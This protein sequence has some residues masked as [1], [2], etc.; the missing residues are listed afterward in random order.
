[1]FQVP[2]STISTIPHALHRRRRAMFANHFSTTSIHNLEPLIQSKVEKFIQRMHEAKLNKKPF[3]L[4]YAFSAMTIDIITL[5]SFGES[6]GCLDSPSFAKHFH[7]VFVQTSLAS[8]V[9]KQFPRLTSLLNILPRRLNDYILPSQKLLQEMQEIFASQARKVKE[10]HATE[11]K[12]LGGGD[13]EPQKLIFESMIDANVP[14]AEKSLRRLTEE[15]QLLVI[16]GTLTTSHT[17]MTISWYLLSNP[18]VLARLKEEF[19]N[20]HDPSSTDLKQ[21]HIPLRTLE[22]LPYLTATIRESLRLGTGVPHRL[23]RVSPTTALHIHGY[24][25]PPGT[26]VSMSAMLMHYNPDVFPEPEALNPDRW[27]P[28]DTEGK[29]LNKYLVPF[30]KGSRQCVGMNLA[31]AEMQLTLAAIFGKNGPKLSLHD[32]VFERDVKTVV[33]A[34]NPLTMPGSEGVKVMVE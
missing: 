7:D 3:P 10:E 4:T 34:F 13:D 8:D 14:A 17:L 11:S 26:P 29:R 24:D 18:P 32:T 21:P 6:Y 30:S 16:A 22:S 5:Y 19:A 9:T 28:L 1:M 33:D 12:P 23:Q 31:W 20:V 2:A 25:L 15:A 27:L